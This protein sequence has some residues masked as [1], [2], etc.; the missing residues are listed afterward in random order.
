M[1]LVAVL[2]MHA[3]ADEKAEPCA[4]DP[5]FHQQDFALGS[6]DVYSADKKVAEALLETSLGGCAIRETWI[7]TN[8]ARLTWRLGDTS[9]D[10]GNGLGLFAYSRLSRRW[11]YFWVSDTGWTTIFT[12]GA[13]QSPGVMLYSAESPLKD[14]GK[15]LRHWSLTLE[16]D[17]AIRERAVGTDDG[18]K[19]TKEYEL[20]WRRKR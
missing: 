12:G 4:D 2:S 5:A 10:A 19:W 14:G 11:G 16:S 20:L 13:L 9:G 18:K 7:A 8:G 3:H 15:R 1:G 17:G 6:W